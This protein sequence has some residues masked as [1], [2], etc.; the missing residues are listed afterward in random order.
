[1]KVPDQLFMFSFV[2]D[3]QKIPAHLKIT[4]KLN[5]IQII[6]NGLQIQILSSTYDD[7]C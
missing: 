4:I 3:L 7:Q 1:M 6:S 2:N 5:I